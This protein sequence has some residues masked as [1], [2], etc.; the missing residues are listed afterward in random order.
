MPHHTIDPLAPSD[1]IS[2]TGLLRWDGSCLYLDTDGLKVS[3][4]WPRGFTS[5]HHGAVVEVLDPNGNVVGRTDGRYVR[6]GGNDILEI[7]EAQYGACVFAGGSGFEVLN[8][9]GRH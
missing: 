9:V 2:L 6:L 1:G 8:V 5:Q 3:L 7:T 4:L